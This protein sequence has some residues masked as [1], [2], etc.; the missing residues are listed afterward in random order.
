MCVPRLEVGGVFG[1]TACFPAPQ[2]TSQ[3]IKCWKPY[4]VIY[5]LALL[6]MGVMMP[7]TCWANGLLINHNCCIWLVSH[8]ISH[9]SVFASGRRPVILAEVFEYF[10]SYSR[11]A[12]VPYR[13]LKLVQY[14]SQKGVIFKN[15][16]R[17]PVILSKITVSY[18]VDR[19]AHY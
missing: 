9:W 7:E 2:D 18:F 16:G 17:R 14:V 3:H 19:S 13:P 4:A 5:G 15:S 8:V 1:H 12:I 6:K 10:L 11:Q